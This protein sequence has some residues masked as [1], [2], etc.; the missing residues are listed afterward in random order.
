V[1]GVVGVDASGRAV[2]PPDRW[3]RELH[4]L[5][6]PPSLEDPAA[7]PPAT[8]LALRPLLLAPAPGESIPPWLADLPAR[9]VVYATLG[10]L[11]QGLHADLFAAIIAGVG[12]ST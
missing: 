5:V 2:G 12:T 4:E 10:T 11:A 9:P 1:Q 3:P 6:V 8:S 7:P